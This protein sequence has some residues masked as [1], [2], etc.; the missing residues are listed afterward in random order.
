MFNVINRNTRK[1][2]EICSKLTIRTPEQRQWHLSSVLIV[3]FEHILH[4]FLVILLLTLNNYMWAGFSKWN[5]SQKIG[6]NL[7]VTK[8]QGIN[9]IFSITIF[10]FPRNMNK[11][12]KSTTK[13]V[14]VL[15]SLYPTLTARLHE[16][17]SK[18][19]PVWDFTS[20]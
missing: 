13:K 10:A 4:H 2:F 5:Q 16:T 6:R 17:R 3:N 12:K 8:K 14:N 19:K 7:R 1:R 11:E 18:L 9:V 20:G 15:V